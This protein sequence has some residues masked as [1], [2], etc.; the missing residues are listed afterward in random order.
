[1]IDRKPGNAQSMDYRTFLL[2]LLLLLQGE[3]P[4]TDRHE[5]G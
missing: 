4:I 2:L 1:L 3:L 5:L